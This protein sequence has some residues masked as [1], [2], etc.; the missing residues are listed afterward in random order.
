[1]KSTM[2]WQGLVAIMLVGVLIPASGCSRNAAPSASPAVA[3]QARFHCPMHPQVVAD[4][5]GSCPICGMDLVPIREINNTSTVV[6]PAE[7]RQRIGLKLGT[8]EKRPLAHE[9]RTSARIV[10]DETRLYHVTLKTEGW[11]EHFHTIYVGKFIQ[12]GEPLM[13]IYSPELLTTA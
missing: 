11:I 2:I 4:K 1:M 12:K 8:V 6:I 10:S 3:K 13:V 7:T 9:I 5:P